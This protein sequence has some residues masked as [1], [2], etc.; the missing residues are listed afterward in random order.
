MTITTFNGGGIANDL[1]GTMTIINSTIAN[2][3]AA[4]NGGGINTVGILTVINSTIAYNSVNPGGAGGGIYATTG[5]TTLY[6]T[7][8]ALNTSGT[9]TTA[10]C[11]RYLGHGQLG[12]RLQLDRHRWLGRPDQSTNDRQSGRSHEPRT[13]HARQ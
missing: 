12:K 7:I 4:Q 2:N 3:N 1:A 10:T 5:T 11:Q 9:G 6:N 13:R 8:V